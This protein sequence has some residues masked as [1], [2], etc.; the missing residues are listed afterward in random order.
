MPRYI[1]TTAE[2]LTPELSAALLER[3]EIH[4][5]NIGRPG[6]VQS[7][8]AVRPRLEVYGR[9]WW[10]RSTGNTYHSVRV[11]LD[12]VEV[13]RCPYAYGY[14]SAYSQ[15]AV[16]LLKQAGIVPKDHRAVSAW[17]L[18]DLFDVVE[19]VEDIQRKKDL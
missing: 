17:G 3:L 1:L 15:T 6:L 9:K 8:E 10:Q 14:G 11:L 5:Q 2:A 7:L 18:S 19:T 4:A 16:E 12:G 13:A